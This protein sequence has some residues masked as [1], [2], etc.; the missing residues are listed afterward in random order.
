MVTRCVEVPLFSSGTSTQFG[1]I[2]LKILDFDENLLTFD[3]IFYKIV[4]SV[5][6]T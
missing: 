1:E 6:N 4:L 3:F 5:Q 2:M